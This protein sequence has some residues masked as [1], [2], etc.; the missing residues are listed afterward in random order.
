MTF[1]SVLEAF[2]KSADLVGLRNFTVREI[3]TA[4]QM[5]IVSRDNIQSYITRLA[6]VQDIDGETVGF[7]Q[8]VEGLRSLIN[9]FIG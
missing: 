4:K 7:Q 3:F 8:R 9:G 1:N 5:K 2:I 6:I